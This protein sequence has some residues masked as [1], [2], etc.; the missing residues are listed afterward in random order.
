MQTLL[1][2]IEFNIHP[3][4]PWGFKPGIQQL[5]CGTD[6]PDYRLFFNIFL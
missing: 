2:C 3:L 6:I 5:H 4:A 1:V